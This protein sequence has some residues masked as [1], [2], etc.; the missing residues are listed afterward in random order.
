MY[1]KKIYSIIFICVTV[2]FIFLIACNNISTGMLT[3][4]R[5]GKTY[6]TVQIGEQ[7]WMAENLAYI[8][9]VNDVKAEEGI[10]VYAYQGDNVE[11]AK[12]TP[13]YQ[14]YGCLYNW[15]A[16]MNI[17]KR[18]RNELWNV[19][20]IEHQGICPD[21]WHLPSDEE[22]KELELYLETNPSFNKDDERRYTGDVGKKLKSTSGWNNDG[23]GNNKSGFCALASGFRYRTGE[24]IK[25]GSY[26]YFWTASQIYP[27][28][29]W[30][31]YLLDISDGTYR[32]FP[33]KSNGMP[34][35]C[36]KNK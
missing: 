30:Y 34:V 35:R 18:Y 3:D 5:D 15:P 28:S 32:G 8:P 33:S 9:Y 2:I 26:G 7:I 13:N 36:V 29:A 21:G 17:E 10:W 14:I 6:K 16:A 20:N 25:M 12:K 23:N 4:S 31:R 24:F 1:K 11:E 27:G 22:W 19:S